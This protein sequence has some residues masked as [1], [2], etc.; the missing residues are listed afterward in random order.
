MEGNCQ[1]EKINMDESDVYASGTA[2]SGSEKKILTL[3]PRVTDTGK[4]R[5]N[6]KDLVK[7][8]EVLNMIPHMTAKSDKCFP[9]IARSFRSEAAIDLASVMDD[10]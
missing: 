6:L 9:R 8:L 1:Y 5:D 10:S 3:I 4:I 2:A 7:F